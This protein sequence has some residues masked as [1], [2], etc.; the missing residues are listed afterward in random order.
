MLHD[1]DR[2]TTYQSALEKAMAAH[3]ADAKKSGKGKASLKEKM[4]GKRA[5]ADVKVLDIGTG[6]GLLAMLAANAG[7]PLRHT[8]LP[9]SLSHA[10]KQTHSL[11]LLHIRTIHTTQHTYTC[12]PTRTRTHTHAHTHTRVHTHT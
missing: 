1:S 9:H 12:T 11:F 3:Q 2:E 6:S 7:P 10:H 8:P 5:R 4:T